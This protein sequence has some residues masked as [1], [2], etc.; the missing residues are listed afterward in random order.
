[1]A[2]IQALEEAVRSGD[3]EKIR[4]AVK[5]LR[6]W[7]NWVGPRYFGL[8]VQ[9]SWIGAPPGMRQKIEEMAKALESVHKEAAWWAQHYIERA[10][11]AEAEGSL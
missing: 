2:L 9:D 4:E 6:R 7:L 11:R 10:R 8:M 5:E 3:E 1:V